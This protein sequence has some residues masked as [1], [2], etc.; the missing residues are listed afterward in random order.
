VLRG[1]ELNVTPGELVGLVGRSGAGKSTLVH[2]LLG[3]YRPE[4]GRILIDG[5]DIAGLTQE[6]LRAQIGMVT[7]DTSLLHRSIRD[8]IRY[9][10]PWASDT[11]I[12]AAA[13]QAE[14]TEF[15]ELLEDWNGRRGF[16]AHVGER[17]VLL[18]TEGSELTLVAGRER[19]QLEHM[20]PE[21]AIG[22]EHSE[23]APD[24]RAAV[25][26]VHAVGVVAEQPHQRV[27]GLR[28]PRHRPATVDDRG[29]E[30]E[31][32]HGRDDDV[33]G[34]LSSA[35]VGDGVGQRPD[36]RQELGERSRV[37]VREQECSS[38]GL[39][40]V[41]ELKVSFR[42]QALPAPLIY[43]DT[44]VKK[45][46]RRCAALFDVRDAKI[47]VAPLDSWNVHES[48]EEPAS[49]LAPEPVV[50]PPNNL[51]A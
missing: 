35:A 9:G 25:T 7:Q 44:R 22:I 28:D 8:N 32:G 10:R 24:H 1:L 45:L 17:G 12:R 40:G 33:E 27:V 36:H 51:S 37:G 16:D 38:A 47:N 50:V 20:R 6:S 21:E 43:V 41:K 13:D 3:F 34:V 49:R 4:S 14:A 2:L 26:A 5:R 18:F 19:E 31:S 11:E 48:E 46:I 15:I 30:A 39:G 29:R 42:A 23:F